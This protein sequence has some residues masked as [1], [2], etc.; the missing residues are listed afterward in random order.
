MPDGVYIAY[1]VLGDGPADVVVGLNSDEGNV[2]LIWDEPDWRPFLLGP[3]EFAR[4]ILHDRRGTGVSSRNV[5]L[6]N[7]ETRVAD[8]L[9]VLDEVDSKRPVL[10][11]GIEPGAMHAMFA[12]THPSRLS[13]LLWNNPAA[14]MA[15]APDYPWGLGQAEYEGSLERVKG[16]GSTRYAEYVMGVRI[17]ERGV[18][19]SEQAAGEQLRVEAFA[20]MNRNTA[21]PDIAEEITRNWWQTDVRAILPQVQAPAALVTGEGD[22]IDETRYVASLIPNAEVHVVAGQSGFSA[23]PIMAILRGLCGAPPDN[24]ALHTVLSAVLF[25]DIVE[26]TARQAALGDHGWKQLVLAHH[27]VV[28]DA[29][30]RWRG[31][32]HDTAGDG[33]FATFEGPAR[34]IHCAL[35]I[36]ERVRTLGLEVRAGVHVGECELIDGKVGGIAVT[37]AAR[38][39]GEAG[40]AQL[41]V[42]RTVK[43]LVAG[44][45]LTFSDVGLH[46]LKGLPERWQLYQ[47]TD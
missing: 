6:P 2:D 44:S 33:F 7:L 37:S 27:A 25:T 3:A 46:D 32:E 47:A 10:A 38:I 8:L 23:E 26:S 43:D 30:T 9:A 5:S 18:A 42:S 35:E 40:P 36:I 1:Q 12:A 4:V 14:R 13:G 22:K 31:V 21:S 45:G 20:R 15:W 16:W 28:R 19:S 24:S 41:Y 17:T 34:A 11:A 39:V 29:L